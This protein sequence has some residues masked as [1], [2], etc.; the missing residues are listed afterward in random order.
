MSDH[1]DLPPLSE[2]QLEIM[3]VVWMQNSCT[4]N[5]VVDAL[6]QRRR[7]ARNTVLTLMTRLAD[8]GWLT[9]EKV[10]RGFVYRATRKQVDVQQSMVRRLLSAAFGGKADGLIMAMV[11]DGALS[12]SELDAI[13]ERIDQASAESGE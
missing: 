13:R 11:D 7:V 1:H 3:N 10:G 5:D 6:N 2:S 9:Q 8:K 12:A 4:V